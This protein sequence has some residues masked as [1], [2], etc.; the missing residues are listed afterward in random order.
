MGLMNC[1]REMN[2]LSR[3]IEVAED[4][5][6][7]TITDASILSRVADAH[8]KLKN[9]K[10][11]EIYYMQAL[12]I[13]PKDQYVI[14][15]LGHLYFACQKYKD[16]IHW[17]EKL[18]LIQPDNIKI[19]TE[20]GNSY[21]KIKDYDEA[22]QYYHRAAELDRKNFFALYGLAESYRGKKD[23]HKAN[24][25]WE[26]ILEFDPDNKLI[27][28]RYADSLRGMGEFDKALEC[29][30][31]ILAEGEDYFA[32][33][34]KASSLKLIGKRDKAEEIYLD[35]HKKF[36]MD[37]RPLL[38]LSDLYVEIDKSIE[39]IRLLED[40]QKKQPLNEEIKHKLENIRGE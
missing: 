3:V 20:I 31:K 33:L 16:A 40:F 14:V 36:P 18:L 25:Y 5:R 11:S 2:L 26:K 15:G 1:Y 24:Q 7:I 30:N 38:E 28:N 21:R 6:H 35:L 29:F 10:E 17:W 19:L 9:F 22:I 8:R 27:I 13:N 34:G 32:L 12:Q 39:A 37:P 23:F 4:Y